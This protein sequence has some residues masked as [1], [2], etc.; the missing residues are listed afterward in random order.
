MKPYNPRT[1]TWMNPSIEYL[2]NKDIIEYDMKDA[3]LNI[4]KQYSLLDGETI[5]NISNMEKMKRYITLGKMQRDNKDFS[6]AL[7]NKFAELRE[8]FLNA[9]K[10]TNNNIISVK[11]DAIY[12]IDSV[13][14]TK[15]GS[16]EFIQKNKYT[17]YI[18]FTDNSNIELYYNIDGIDIKGMGDSAINRHRIYMLSFIKK[19]IGYLEEKSISVK[20]YL[21]NFIDDYKNDRLDEEFYLEFNNLSKD[22]NKVFNYQKLIIPIVQITIKEIK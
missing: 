2:F 15:F 14:H 22:F 1:M 18:R 16:I 5:R 13:S 4:I 19:V 9:N 6:I 21:K 17:S 10:L 12:T 7:Q 11:N 8:S 20:R 3:S